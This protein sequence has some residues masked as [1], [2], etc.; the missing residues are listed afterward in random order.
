V[1]NLDEIKELKIRGRVLHEG[2]THE[3]YLKK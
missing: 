1:V 3:R 2:K